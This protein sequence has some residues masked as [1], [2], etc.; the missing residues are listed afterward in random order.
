MLSDQHLAMPHRR[1]G[2]IISYSLTKSKGERT[3]EKN[4]PFVYI[5]KVL[6]FFEFS[7]LKWDKE[8]SAA[9]VLWFSVGLNVFL[10][11]WTETVLTFPKPS[12][13]SLSDELGSFSTKTV[14]MLS[15]NSLMTQ[16]SQ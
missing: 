1:G 14:Q 2:W 11:H 12:L 9:F 16:W 6:V 13:R 3:R 8:K 15:Y 5:E 7:S 10:Q 4:R